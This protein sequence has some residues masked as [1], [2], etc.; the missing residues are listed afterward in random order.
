MS[1]PT[2]GVPTAWGHL[3]LKNLHA[4]FALLNLQM[5]KIT[6][7][8]DNDELAGA[9]AIIRLGREQC[10][11]IENAYKDLWEMVRAQLQTTASKEV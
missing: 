7:D 6:D 2:Y 11:E 1:T 10:E 8:E 9:L 5:R 3:A 4:V